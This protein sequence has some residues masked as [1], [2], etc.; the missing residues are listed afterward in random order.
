MRSRRQTLGESTYDEIAAWYDAWA[1]SSIDDDP[2][3]RSA[4]ALISGVSGTR[5]GEHA[6]S[7]T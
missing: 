2:F 7:W 6:G 1:G 4:E 3:F 5:G